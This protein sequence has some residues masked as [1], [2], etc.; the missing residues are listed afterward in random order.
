M[1]ESISIEAKGRVRQAYSFIDFNSNK[2]KC[3][4][5]WQPTIK[6]LLFGTECTQ[7]HIVP[8]EDRPLG[9]TTP[10]I[11]RV[12]ATEWVDIVGPNPAYFISMDHCIDP[13]SNFP[14][15]DGVP[16]DVQYFVYS[17]AQPSDI[18]R[19]KPWIR[20]KYISR[21]KGGLGRTWYANL[22]VSICKCDSNKQIYDMTSSDINI[23]KRCVS[24]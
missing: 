18:L 16:S 21:L 5:I 7:A 20:N 8:V 9:N 23:A 14:D 13:Y 19:F 6:G 4:Y 24:M 22:V 15:D 17:E 11:D 3:T 10:D 2:C 12:R 1:M